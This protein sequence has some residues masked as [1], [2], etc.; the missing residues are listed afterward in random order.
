MP[1]GVLVPYPYHVHIVKLLFSN[2]KQSGIEGGTLAEGPGS[3]VPS[4]RQV[5]AVGAEGLGASYPTWVTGAR[6]RP[7]EHRQGAGTYQIP[8]GVV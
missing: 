5:S 7:A 8:G 2:L 3:Q 6:V 4:Q 1:Q